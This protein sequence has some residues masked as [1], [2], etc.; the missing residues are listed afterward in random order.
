[1][2]WN[3]PLN[4]VDEYR[5]EIPSSYKRGMNTS[6]L[7]FADEK[8]MEQVKKDNALEQVA[9]VAT[10]PGIVGMSM[11]MPDIHWGY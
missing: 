11:A 3:G 4:K 10:I 1:M 2:D 6:G 9:N 8:M 7:I 5:Y